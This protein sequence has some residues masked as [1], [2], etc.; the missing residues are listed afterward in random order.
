MPIY[1]Y[2]CKACGKVEEFLLVGQDD[3]SVKCPNCGS[4]DMER[5]LSTASFLSS[6]GGRLPGKTC[7][8]RDERCETPPCSTGGTCRREV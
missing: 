7:C 6:S 1:E 3:I 5:V 4:D 2:R 8:G